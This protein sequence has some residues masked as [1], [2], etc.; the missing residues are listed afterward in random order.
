VKSVRQTKLDA[1]VEL[2]TS[3]SDQEFKELRRRLH[4]LN[5]ESRVLDAFEAI[6]RGEGISFSPEQW[7]AYKNAFTVKKRGKKHRIQSTRV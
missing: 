4:N 7:D 3:L 6:E 1:A 2:L 5:Y